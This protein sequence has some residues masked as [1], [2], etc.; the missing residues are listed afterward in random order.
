MSLFN[1]IL[2]ILK[3]NEA[4]APG[5]D[6]PKIVTLKD[7]IFDWFKASNVDIA[8]FNQGFLEP[9]LAIYKTDQRLAD[10]MAKDP[11]N[12]YD[13][14]FDQHAILY[15]AS[16]NPSNKWM[17]Y[18][19]DY[20]MDKSNQTYTLKDSLRSV[21]HRHLLKDHPKFLL[22][23]KKGLALLKAYHAIHDKRDIN[24]SYLQ[25]LSGLLTY[26]LYDENIHSLVTY[27]NEQKFP[28]KTFVFMRAL[29]AVIFG[30][31]ETSNPATIKLLKEATEQSI[32]EYNQEHEPKLVWEIIYDLSTSISAINYSTTYKETNHKKRK[33]LSVKD[34]PE[35]V[36]L[37]KKHESHPFDLIACFLYY[38]SNTYIS[39][40]QNK[41]HK[42]IAK[43]LCN[44]M[45]IGKENFRKLL[46]MP[47]KLSID[48]TINHIYHPLFSV[49]QPTLSGAD[50]VLKTFENKILNLANS[51]THFNKYQPILDAILQTEK[52]YNNEIEESILSAR[53]N[54][55]YVKV[56]YRFGQISLDLPDK[57]SAQDAI[58]KLIEKLNLLFPTSLKALRTNINYF[59][60][61]NYPLLTLNLD[62]EDINFTTG[63]VNEL[64]EILNSKKTGYQLI[65]IP[66]NKINYLEYTFLNCSLELMN[67]AQ[68]DY[69]KSVY[70]S[71]RFPEINGN[72]LYK[73]IIFSNKE[74]PILNLKNKDDQPNNQSNNK[75]LSD[76]TWK[77]F[78]DEYIDQLT[79]KEKWHDLM[80]HLIECK[81]SKKPNK[82]WLE[83]LK[84][85]INGIGIDRYFRELGAMMA[86]SLKEEFWFIET[87]RTTIKGVIWSCSHYPSDESFTIIKSIVES[88]YKKIPGIGPKSAAVGNLG[89][90][91]LVATGDERAFGLLNLMR[92]KSKYQRYI[93][94]IDK[95]LEKFQEFSDV[96]AEVLADRTIPSFN[97]ESG[98]KT[99]QINKEI[100]VV[101]RIKKRALSKKWIVNG[102]ELS[103][104]P[105]ILKT[106]LKKEEKEIAAEFKRI[107]SLLKDIR[108]RVKTYWLYDR[109]WTF[110]EWEK[111]LS[112]HPLIRPW[113]THLIWK[114][115]TS[116]TSFI[117]SENNL[118]GKN[119][120]A[121]TPAPNDIISCWHPVSSSAGEIKD[122]QK[123]II[124]RK[125]Q[126]PLRQAFREHYPFSDTELKMEESERF[127]HHFLVVR[128][129]MAIANA[130]GWTFT[131]AHE[132]DS[133]PRKFIKPLNITVHQKCDYSRA[134]YAIPTK[135][136]YFT[137]GNSTN[138][139]HRTKPPK[140]KLE[141]IPAKTRSELCRDIDLFISQCSIANDPEL[142]T[143]SE[144][145]KYY[146]E[147]FHKGK[148]SDNAS[149]KIRKEIIEQLIPA[150]G[151]GS[152]EFEKNFLLISGQLN[153]YRINLGSGFAQIEN[154]YQHLNL[155]PDISPIKK[156]RKIHIP[157]QDDETL[158]I[159][160]AK[161]IFLKNDQKI[162]DQK[163]KDMLTE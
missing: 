81:G 48:F 33:H 142:S 102:K 12:S 161:A 95:A 78:K 134:D 83:E 117:L 114:N 127:G 62:G 113:I 123:F 66:F 92:N 24:F 3:R 136:M 91:A 109:K 79:S 38:I 58:N 119:G 67:S 74:A 40:D 2:N 59:M 84:E 55:L 106:S 85:K 56:N 73:K 116:H 130:A 52:N 51:N 70:L 23:L 148:F 9:C 88:A 158:Y 45:D 129:L 156:N 80:H 46:S 10:Y 137:N 145:H 149:A 71:N 6:I 99:I 21:P 126:Q 15:I 69:L 22:P 14:Y 77:W 132:S 105:D 50:P 153:N 39:S 98:E 18:L 31:G 64:N 63:I 124:S 151:L 7:I 30:T 87:Y 1:R 104:A 32:A 121:I 112:R 139:D 82:K 131:Y 147:D 57:K 8:Q 49:I 29:P 120:E 125:I 162:T 141:E 100:S 75:F 111:N 47:I 143:S 37:I 157:I 34:F 155:L 65:P 128:K 72:S 140:L 43:Q 76:P 54:N 110:A 94:T 11:E 42:E 122:W 135:T 68:F 101:F 89:I 138:L 4:D 96:D 152:P 27:L 13:R 97:F 118:I 28:E 19:F 160:L 144:E 20:L 93:K 25:Q 86:P 146:R 5:R 41:L 61:E 154:S 60:V 44:N 108:S 115:E 150:L 107:N 16:I 90:S 103:K 163:I 36:S 17:K 53:Y 35:I 133:W 26:D 159:I